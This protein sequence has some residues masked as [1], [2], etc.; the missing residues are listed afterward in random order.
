[1]ER[2]Y[3]K[4]IR[5][6]IIAGFSALLFIV[7]WGIG[8][9]S[10][11]FAAR[12]MTESASEQLT[13]LASQGSKVVTRAIHEE[14]TALLVLA[15]N[16][17]ISN[18][19]STWEEKNQV[20]QKEVKRVDAVN[21]A[22][23]D[24][25]GMTKSPEGKDV[26]IKDRDYFQRAIKGETVV[27]DPIE[28]KTDPGKM[29]MVFAVPVKSGSKTIGVL[30]KAADGNQLSKITNTITFGKSGVAYMVNKQ[31]TSVANANPDL[32]LKQDNVIHNAK[33][34]SS[35]NDMANT[36]ETMLQ[37]KSGSGKYA[38][39]GVEKY[40]GYSPVEG[41]DWF[42]AVTAP[43]KEILSGLETMKY[44]NLG[45]G[46]G[47]V[48]VGIIV[49]LILASFITKSIK[50]LTKKLD[51]IAEG[52]FSQPIDE[53]L[54]K[55]KDETGMLARAADKMQKSIN[56]IIQTVQNQAQGVN[57]NVLNQ[58]DRV[59]DLMSQIEEVSATTE[60][61]S[62]SMQET[63]AASE[64]INE[65]AGGI[66]KAVETLAERA[67]EGAQTVTE[68]YRRASIYKEASLK[69]QEEAQ[70]M[71][72]ETSGSMN[73][74]V[75]QSKDVEQINVLSH[76][77]LQI[78]EQ[79]NLLALNASIEAARAGEAGRG[80][81]VVA[82]EIGRLAY[83]SKETVAEIQKVT[84]SVIDAVENL[85]DTSMKVL[86][87][88]NDKVMDD[89]KSLVRL[90]GNYQTDAET[91]DLLVT[92]MSATSEE[93][94]SSITNIMMSINGISL[95]TNEGAEGTTSIAQSVSVV[96]QEAKDVVDYAK[97]TKE[98]TDTLLDAVSVFK[99]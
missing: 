34:D 71:Y 26:S 25:T 67:Q 2:D 32:V 68:I 51:I 64:E 22:F 38:Y 5:G 43:K 99:I 10:Y 35:L 54:L 50:H 3:M 58:Q 69:A 61:L 87:F 21:I 7:C 73:Y 84:K 66:E 85:S 81:S 39:N 1:M 4:S 18:E 91:V 88:L 56:Q 77:V 93:L 86:M 55:I 82:E 52:D 29:I 8:I 45:I 31:G 20:L 97:N 28:N 40:I 27:S 48:V 89:Y 6:K 83:S 62:A 15:D 47:F 60:E 74:A 46:F 57:S 33:K 44:S 41:S 11:I 59:M 90:S 94:L 76:S 12:A 19:G 63:A 98:S 53:R 17:V 75:E 95:A 49:S 72:N 30:F 9:A 78:A 92:D 70:N 65:V 23:A 96:S 80:F 14:W 42:L 16:D 24:K 36:V 13:A 79:T 37:G